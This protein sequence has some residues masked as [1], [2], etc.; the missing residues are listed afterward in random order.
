MNDDSSLLAQTLL[1]RARHDAM[2]VKKFCGDEDLAEEIIGFH[3]Q[4][5]TEKSIKAVLAMNRVHFRKT[6]DIAA[7]VQLCLDHR[8]DVPER[9]MDED[10][11]TDFAVDQRYGFGY[12][13]PGLEIDGPALVK[14]LYE[15][16]DWAAKIVGVKN[17]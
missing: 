6:H 5:A 1:E 4:Q 17:D 9:L 15:I 7:L 10:K 14:R 2:A 13:S 16:V 11:L 12:E 3:A 8:I